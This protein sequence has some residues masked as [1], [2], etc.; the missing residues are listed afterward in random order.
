MN[1]YLSLSSLLLITLIF[2]S[3]SF[4]AKPQVHI[5]LVAQNASQQNTATTCAYQ[6]PA[7]GKDCK[8][9]TVYKTPLFLATDLKYVELIRKRSMGIT[10]SYNTQS[11]LMP[12]QVF[13][14]VK[15]VFALKYRLFTDLGINCQAKLNG[16]HKRLF[17]GDG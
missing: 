14:D 10:N 6:F 11:T 16:A 17:V 15:I 1:K 13:E 9:V 12:G 4:A 8:K 2:S 5:A 3:N 7:P